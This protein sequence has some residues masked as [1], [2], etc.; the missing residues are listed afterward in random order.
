MLKSTG[1]VLLLFLLGIYSLRAQIVWESTGG[2]VGG[3]V[4]Q[5]LKTHN[6]SFLAATQYGSLYRSTDRGASWQLRFNPPTSA[7]PGNSYRGLL[8]NSQGHIFAAH[9]NGGVIRSL[10]DGV[11]WEP[12]GSG[13]EFRR[14]LAL[15]IGPND[16]LFVATLLKGIWHSTNNGRTWK[17][18]GNE[19]SSKAVSQTM[20]V[21]DDG[22]V[23]VGTANDGLFRCFNRYHWLNDAQAPLRNAPITTIMTLADGS[24]V[25]G[26]ASEGVYISRDGGIAWEILASSQPEN[27]TLTSLMLA[28]DGTYFA[29]WSQSASPL[30]RLPFGAEAWEPFAT[31]GLSGSIQTLI[32]DED[33][34]FFAGTNREAVARSSDGLATW[35]ESNIGLSASEIV[36]SAVLPQGDVLVSSPGGGERLLLYRPADR[37]WRII[38]TSDAGERFAAFLVNASGSIFA[39]ASN[40]VVQSDD[41]GQSWTT[42][43]QIDEGTGMH[44]IVGGPDGYIFATA[45]FLG[46][47]NVALESRDDGLTWKPIEGG[48]EFQVQDVVVN[49][50]RQVFIATAQGLLGT[51]D[52]GLTWS[53]FDNELKDQSIIHLAIGSRDEIYAFTG[54]GL[55]RSDD[56]ESFVPIGTGLPT[57]GV[58]A[59]EVSP[60]GAPI[61]SDRLGRV[62]VSFNRGEDWHEVSTRGRARIQNFSFSAAGHIYAGSFGNGLFQSQNVLTDLPEPTAPTGSPVLKIA[63]N[64]VV[65]SARLSFSLSAA[66][67][68]RLEVIDARGSVVALLL[69]GRVEA[70]EQHID[71]SASGLAN[72]LYY[73]VLHLPGGSYVQPL[74]KRD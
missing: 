16:E 65:E 24:I 23:Y 62:Y 71:W 26:L 35:E 38:S 59:L 60:S 13:L 14:L 53:I 36:A 39:A 1:S 11:N 21:G 51:R 7:F 69:E 50:Q 45:D 6:G 27:A 4:L 17:A 37:S 30:W 31:S 32:E 56:G 54:S 43:A 72:G 68:L 25:A 44:H 9:H 10:D 66:A 55:M 61:L 70:G 12:W 19:F 18:F 74:V 5:L 40:G 52:Q 22:T 49:S 2:P 58:L 28:A 63:P 15:A 42:V 47:Q 57:S 34:N 46:Q 33:H 41:N 3:T 73:G 64:P 48:N 8:S 20:A 29:G 67:D